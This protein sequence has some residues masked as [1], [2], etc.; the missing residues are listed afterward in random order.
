MCHF[1]RHQRSSSTSIVFCIMYVTKKSPW[2]RGGRKKRSTGQRVKTPWRKEE[3]N[4]RVWGHFPTFPGAFWWHF[5]SKCQ[6]KVIL[7]LSLNIVRLKKRVGIYPEWAPSG[8]QS[9]W[10][11][12]GVRGS[13]VFSIV[14]QCCCSWSI[15]NWQLEHI[16]NSNQRR[17]L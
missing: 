16:R 12:P 5:A 7:T 11:L 3:P 9:S 4:H 13:A 1:V 15:S 8:R 14:P 10:W 6:T 17:S 2:Q